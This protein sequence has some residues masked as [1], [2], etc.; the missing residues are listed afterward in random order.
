MLNKHWWEAAREAILRLRPRRI[1]DVGPAE[2]MLWRGYGFGGKH[3]KRDP[4]V[5]REWFDFGAH[6]VLVDI[7]MY[8]H[9]LDFVNASGELLPFPDK[10]F[11]LVIS[12]EVIEHVVNVEAF[13]S[14][15]MRVG[16][17]WVVTTPAAEAS[18]LMDE[19]SAEKLFW[20]NPWLVNLITAYPN[21]KYPHRAHKRVF[22]KEEL[23][24]LFPGSQVLELKTDAPESHWLVLN[25]SL[26]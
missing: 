16:R 11:D 17:H 15:I 13:A 9:P 20:M 24:R 10:S 7:D 25:F 4:R 26:N 18:G 21:D 23:E 5:P 22:T 2:A 3:N 8:K 14:E 1:L 19:E 6:V 12:T